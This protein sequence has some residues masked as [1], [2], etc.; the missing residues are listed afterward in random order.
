MSAAAVLA[1]LDYSLDVIPCDNRACREAESHPET[2]D[3]QC[4]S[5][6]HGL[7][8][9]ARAAAARAYI[10]ARIARTGDVCLGAAA[11]DDEPVVR[12]PRA[13][14]SVAWCTPCMTAADDC[15]C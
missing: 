3:C 10:A 14:R 11:A 9:R 5:A 13:R 15:D 8:F 1:P 7:P 2:C 4:G 6:G 12:I